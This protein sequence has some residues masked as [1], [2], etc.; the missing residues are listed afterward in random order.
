M[1]LLDRTLNKHLDLRNLRETLGFH[2]A[3]FSNS[4][5]QPKIYF[6]VYDGYNIYRSESF[7][8]VIT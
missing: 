5:Q 4:Q 3:R 7:L 1:F 6:E 8:L 2:L